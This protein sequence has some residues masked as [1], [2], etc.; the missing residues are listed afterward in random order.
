V[1]A[2]K[3]PRAPARGRATGGLGPIW[4][5]GR[6]RSCLEST[7]V[8]KNMGRRSARID[9]NVTPTEQYSKETER[10]DHCTQEAPP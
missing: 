2:P 8:E 6:V 9:W 1:L 10:P 4:S 7:G 3:G 5:I